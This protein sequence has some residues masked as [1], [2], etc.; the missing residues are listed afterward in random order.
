MPRKFSTT[1]CGF[2]KFLVSFFKQLVVIQSASMKPSQ[3]HLLPLV[4]TTSTLLFLWETADRIKH[5]SLARKNHL[6][7][8]RV[9]LQETIFALARVFRRLRYTSL[10][11]LRAVKFEKQYKNVNLYSLTSFRAF[12]LSSHSFHSY[13]LTMLDSMK[14]VSVCVPLSHLVTG[15]SIIRPGSLPCMIAH[16]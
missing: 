15:A 10:N 1:N 16:Q 14:C 9:S 2:F 8:R 4:G 7:A 11:S 13:D 5:A 6:P 12:L 3:V